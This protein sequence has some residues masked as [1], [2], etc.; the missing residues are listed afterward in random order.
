MEESKANNIS[1]KAKNKISLPSIKQDYVENKTL[2]QKIDKL[3]KKTERISLE[4]NTSP[5]IFFSHKTFNLK[6]KN[7]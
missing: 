2:Q 5:P 6:E 4:K 7:I 1:I 3:F